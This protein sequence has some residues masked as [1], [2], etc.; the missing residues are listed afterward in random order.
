MGY[1]TKPSSLLAWF[2]EGAQLFPNLQGL[3][4]Q[5]PRVSETKVLRK[6]TK[7]LGAENERE[8]RKRESGR[9]RERRG[10]KMKEINQRGVSVESQR[11]TREKE[12][13]GER[14]RRVK[15]Y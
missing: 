9:K 1:K 3:S 7:K 14:E 8:E 6:K 5:L 15:Y 11:W 12:N 2:W 13:D 4:F 10:K